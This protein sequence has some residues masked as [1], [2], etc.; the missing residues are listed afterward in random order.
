V[1]RSNKERKEEIAAG[2]ERWIDGVI[3]AQAVRTGS[4]SA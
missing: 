2:I 1:V 3:A 4:A